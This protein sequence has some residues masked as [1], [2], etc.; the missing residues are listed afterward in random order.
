MYLARLRLVHAYFV[1]IL[2]LFSTLR[3]VHLS[4]RACSPYSPRLRTRALRFLV[5]CRNLC[6]INFGWCRVVFCFCVLGFLLYPSLPF[7]GKWSLPL[8]VALSLKFERSRLFV[9]YINSSQGRSNAHLWEHKLSWMWW[10][11]VKSDCSGVRKLDFKS[12]ALK[13]FTYA[14][15]NCCSSACDWCLPI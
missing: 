8:S 4:I 7:S 15:C 5:R 10:A 12:D 3:Y 6:T 1:D 2:A 14:A 9:S 13:S 11:K